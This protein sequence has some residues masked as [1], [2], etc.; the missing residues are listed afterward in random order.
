MQRMVT[1]S[2]P[3]NILQL[4]AGHSPNYSMPEALVEHLETIVQKTA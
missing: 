1:S 3:F 4:D 2:M